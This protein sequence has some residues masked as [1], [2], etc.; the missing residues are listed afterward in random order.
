MFKREKNVISPTIDSD[1]LLVDWKLTRGE[2]KKR[3]E[4]KKAA[5]AAKFFA[6]RVISYAIHDNIFHGK[7]KC[8]VQVETLE[9]RQ[10][11]A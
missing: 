10:I 1:S 4:E 7:F 6:P 11:E 5:L 2:K 3:I 8:T 9:N